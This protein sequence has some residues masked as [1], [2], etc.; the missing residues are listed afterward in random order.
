[1]THTHTTHSP[2]EITDATLRPELTGYATARLALAY[3]IAING[4]ILMPFLVTAIMTRLHV[5]EGMAT[6]IAGVEI[7]GVALACAV[8]PRWIARGAHAFAVAGAVGTIVGQVASDLAPSIALMSAARAVSGVFE[9]M[10]FVVVASS[11]AHRACADSIW[12]KINVLAGGINGSVLVAVSLLPPIWFGRWLFALLAGI[13]AILA[14]FVVRIDRFAETSRLSLAGT[15]AR[16]PKRLVVALWIV[17]VLIYGAQASQW[18]VAGIV[19][20]RAGLSQTTIGILLSVSSLL[21]FA[22]AIVPMQR[23]CHPYRL[24]IIGLAQLVMIV[25]I[26]VFFASTGA[27]SYFVSQLVLNCAFFAIVPFL[28]GLLSEIDPD[29]SLVARTVVVTFL[30]VGTGTA[31]AGPLFD[32]YGSRHCAYMMGGAIVAAF[33]LVWIS[34]KGSAQHLQLSAKSRLG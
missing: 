20:E 4:T 7:L 6:Q 33:P 16:L 18:A 27:T 11:V 3:A 12:G 32:R 26:T 34:L 22:G 14:P 9:G 19:G 10:L 1:M 2:A 17:T 8:L 30:G 28:T 13:V 5:D 21:G 31:L 15:P 23:A 24:T 25:C 29:G